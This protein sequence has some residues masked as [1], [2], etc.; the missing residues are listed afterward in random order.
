[1]AR[2]EFAD[3]LRSLRDEANISR[4]EL[5]TKTGITYAALSKYETGEREPDFQTLGKI[6][7]Y[8]DVSI[9]YLLGNSKV[10]TPEDILKGLPAEARQTAELFIEFLYSKFKVKETK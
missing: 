9:D 6:A 3:K 1:V 7:R 10:K 4:E 8:F 2:L 5:A